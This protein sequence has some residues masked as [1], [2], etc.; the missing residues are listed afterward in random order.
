MGKAMAA[1]DRIFAIVETKSKINAIEMDEDKSK[2]RLS[3]S[4]VKG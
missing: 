3:I 1:A 2:K 4:E